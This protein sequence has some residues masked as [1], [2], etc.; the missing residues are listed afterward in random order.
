[1]SLNGAGRPVNTDKHQEIATQQYDPLKIFK[2]TALSLVKNLASTS[3]T[4]ETMEKEA[5]K[6]YHS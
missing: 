2:D 5:R 3:L 1:M 6:L 4:N